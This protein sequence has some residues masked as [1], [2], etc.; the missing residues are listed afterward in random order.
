MLLREAPGE[1]LHE[2]TLSQLEDMVDLQV[3][4]QAKWRDRRD[5][6]LSLGLPDWRGPALA[7]AIADVVTRTGG[8][9]S[10]DERSALADFVEGLP[11]RFDQVASCGLPDTLVH[12][13]FHSGNFR[14]DKCGLTLLDWGDSGVGHPLLDQAAFFERL[15]TGVVPVMKEF[16]NSRLLEQFP[17]SDPAKA[18]LLLA[19]IAAAR[20]AVTYR[21]FLD[22]IEE[23]EHPYHQADPAKWLRRTVALMR[24]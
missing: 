14:G 19:P 20:Q 18:A 4:I 11:L 24:H 1:D 16:W 3:G 7:S 15:P 12:G 10:R 8:Q 21:R 5:L 17:E 22:N 2:A 6:L 13:D 23:S 9:L